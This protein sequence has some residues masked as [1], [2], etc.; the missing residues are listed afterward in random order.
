MNR[1][2]KVLCVALV[3]VLLFSSVPAVS[4]SDLGF[5]ITASALNATGKCGKTATYTF[6][7]ATGKLTIEGTGKINAEA[8]Y[9]NQDIKEVVIGD[10]ITEIGADAFNGSSITSVD[11][12]NGVTII[13]NRAFHICIALTSVVIPDNVITIGEQV[14]EFCSRLES[15]NI[16]D[17][18]TSIGSNAFFNCYNLAN[19]DIG[20]RVEFIGG[21]AFSNCNN[22]INVIIPDGVTNIG[23][24]AFAYCYE[25]VSVFIGNNVKNI[26]YNSFYDCPNL[27]SIN[28]PKTVTYIGSEAFRYCS[29]LYDVYY[30]G[31][32]AEWN[33]IDI[34]A[35]NTGLENAEIHFAETHT[36]TWDVEEITKYPTCTEKGE[37]IIKC[38]NAICEKLEE[39]P[40]TGHEWI[41]ASC[42]TPKTCNK[43]GVTEGEALGHTFAEQKLGGKYLKSQA[44][45]GKK[46]VY[47]YSCSVCG[48][49]S[50]NTAEEKTFEYGTTP[51]HNWGTAVKIAATCTEDEMMV[52]T[53]SRCNQKYVKKT[54]VKALGHSYGSDGKCKNAGC[55]ETCPHSGK[56]E[57]I[58]GKP[59]TCTN[60]GVSD[61]EK[62]KD[63]GVVT[64]IQIVIPA[65]GHVME[66]YQTIQPTCTEKGI[67]HGSC[68][69]CSYTEEIEL[70]PLGHFYDIFEGK[71]P[72]CT[73]AGYYIY[74]CRDCNIEG[75]RE[76][77]PATGHSYPDKW[78]VVIAPDCQNTGFAV[79]VCF[80]CHDVIAQ[81]VP[82]SGHADLDGDSKCDTCEMIIVVE[83]E[84]PTEPDTPDI[85]DAPE[86]KPCDCDCHAGGIKAFFFNFLNFFAKLFDKSARV[87]KCGASH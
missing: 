68:F 47:Y 8:F 20:S 27:E 39:I 32:E 19:V 40:A 6:D 84:E 53:C 45:C 79:K 9:R 56:K 11:F 87:C 51:D 54:S 38:K 82:K 10:G 44:T 18:V 76:D 72:T 62:C 17:G 7:S 52:Q 15:I 14:F 75:Y 35:N 74:C 83:P 41:H 71:Y 4:V 46:A 21:G 5:G 22:L 66:Y 60:P 34:R 28:I 42:T 57:T 64:K 25:L 43:C 2:R 73:E 33:A 81:T 63:C 29:S 30:A 23:A 61:G 48:E 70:K 67:K 59:A 49:S 1:I 80:N 55:T 37:K 65:L 13:G 26:H 85:P 69:N 86:E 24:G 78:S 16:G 31:S 36:H 58:Y 12:G 77:V 3:L 50:A